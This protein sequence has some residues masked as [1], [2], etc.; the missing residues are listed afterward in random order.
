MVDYEGWASGGRL[1]SWELTRLLQECLGGLEG[2][3]GDAGAEG[4]AAQEVL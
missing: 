1:D 4:V 3:E 2:L